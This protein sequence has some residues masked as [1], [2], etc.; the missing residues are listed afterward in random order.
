VEELEIE[1]GAVGLV[2]CT[3]FIEREDFVVWL[4]DSVTGEEIRESGEYLRGASRRV[5]REG[6]SGEKHLA[7]AP[8]NC[9]CHHPIAPS[10]FL[11]KPYTLHVT[12]TG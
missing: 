5:R 10:A 4:R 3:V 6:Q 7:S 11:P 12:F 2:S 8:V 1:V 9:P